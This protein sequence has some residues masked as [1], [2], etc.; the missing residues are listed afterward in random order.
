MLVPRRVGVPERDD[1]W[2]WCQTEWW[3]PTGLPIYEGHH[4]AHEGPFNRSAA[5]NRASIRAGAW[6]VAL[7]LDADVVVDPA[8][9]RS[10]V[11]LAD[12]SGQITWP[13]DRFAGLDRT[14]SSR[15]RSGYSGS[16][17]PGVAHEMLHTASSAVCVPRR[18]WDRVGGFDEAFIGWGFEDV[19][20]SLAC[21]AIG[22]GHHRIAGTVYHLWHP[23]AEATGDSNHPVWQAN[24]AVCAPY[25]DAGWAD[26][27]AMEAVLRA[28]GQ[29]DRLA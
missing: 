27:D 8:A 13:F 28:N 14:M 6:D 16:W 11:L 21:Q 19:A 4:E 26:G 18:L 1:L 3:A 22:G 10:A 17:E 29:W 23:P 5:I 15:V 2:S 7:I 25:L 12:A 24:A 20:F 9:V